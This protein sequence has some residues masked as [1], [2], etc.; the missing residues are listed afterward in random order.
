MRRA[1]V[2]IWYDKKQSWTWE[3]VCVS[4]K[5]S[6]TFAVAS[7]EWV[8]VSS[9]FSNLKGISNNIELSIK[10]RY[11]SAQI[12]ENLH[13]TST[14]ETIGRALERVCQKSMNCWIGCLLYMKKYLTLYHQASLPTLMIPL[15]IAQYLIVAACWSGFLLHFLLMQ[16]DILRKPQHQIVWSGCASV[17]E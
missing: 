14:F 6:Y 4:L 5:W 10:N 13:Q 3:S 11:M 9:S 12:Q 8:W 16:K 7:P 1:S 17:P 2:R 15:L